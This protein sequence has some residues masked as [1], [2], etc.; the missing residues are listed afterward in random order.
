MK[1]ILAMEKTAVESEL[2]NK[3]GILDGKLF[4][5]IIT[6][7]AANIRANAEMINALNVFPV[8]DG[9]TGS[10]M[11]MTMDNG[12]A[13]LSGEELTLFEAAEAVS[14]GMLMGARG[15]SGVILSQFFYG[16]ARG[17]EGMTEADAVQIGRAMKEGV[18][19]AYSAVMKP[20]E[21]TILTVAR[22]SVE[23][24]VA[25]INENS[26]AISVFSD[27]TEEAERS[28]ERTP[29]LLPILKEAGVVD[30]GGM[31][32]LKIMEG[33]TA[34]LEGKSVTYEA[35]SAMQ[36]STAAK[37]GGFGVDSEMTYGY[38]TELLLQLQNSKTDVINFD[39][40]NLNAFLASVGNSIVSFMN[41]SIV[42]IHVHTLTPEKVLEFCRRY[43]EFLTVKI[44]NM[45][46]QHTGLEEEKKDEKPVIEK[47]FG[48]VAVCSGEGMKETFEGI[49]ADVVIDGGQTNN[50][51]AGDFL[52]AFKNVS[53]EHIFVFPN[54]S[55]IILAAKQAADMYKD[56]DV[57]V[58]ESKSIGA[59]YVG[60]S[61]FD[62][63]SGD[64]DEIEAEI[65][66]SMA[67]VETAHISVAVRDAAING[68][69]I[70]KGDIMGLIGKLV[71][72][73]T[74]D[75]KKAIAGVIDKLFSNVKRFMLT[76]FCGAEADASVTEF[77]KNYF[78]EKVAN[79]EIYLIN[80]GQSVYPY[81][82]VAE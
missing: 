71:A 9:D 15:N 81:I 73:S 39:M 16:V 22:E 74:P 62:T 28:L 8:P 25:N 14:Q 66:D 2:K 3:T 19:R 72:I 76:V 78:K 40:D 63:S 82:L 26:D 11:S 58:I 5:K 33:M 50:P 12:A 55:N 61:S 79:G 44:E 46:V 38:C 54:N 77:L 17:L 27:M 43:G 36:K 30:S 60:I 1:G 59:G 69:N 75:I 20:A 47:E 57:R 21:G 68:V 49:G 48:I 24:A 37:A 29:E 56:A 35:P 41:G 65:N 42:K 18:K 51:S 67:E 70:R 7:G 64:T 23:Y 6:A 53:A 4:A 13:A 31:G 34:V 45:S 80:G 32:L 10:N 52:Q